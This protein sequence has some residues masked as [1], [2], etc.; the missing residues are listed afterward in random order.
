MDISLTGENLTGKT[1]GK[2]VG[3]SP[4]YPK[5][6]SEVKMSYEVRMEFEVYQSGNTSAY[7]LSKKAYSTLP[8]AKKRFNDLFKKLSDINT[9]DHLRQRLKEENLPPINKK[10][11]DDGFFIFETPKRSEEPIEAE[12]TLKSY[13]GFDRETIRIR[14]IDPDAED[15]SQQIQGL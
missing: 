14:L 11:F 10:D 5:H 13:Y 2:D 15:N 1:V 8:E 3:S 7:I 12:N 4:T 6:F 9:W